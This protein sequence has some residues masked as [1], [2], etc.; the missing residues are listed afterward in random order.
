MKLKNL[1]KVVDKSCLVNITFFAY[2]IYYANTYVDG[3]YTCEEVLNKVKPW[4]FD[5][6]VTDMWFCEGKTILYISCEICK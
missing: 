3:V 5:T 2:G 1:L 6:K 4:L